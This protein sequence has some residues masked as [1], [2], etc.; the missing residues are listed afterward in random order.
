MAD[1]LHVASLLVYLHP[2]R[3]AAAMA[4]IEQLRGTELHG[5][6]P[7]GKVI[8]VIESQDEHRITEHLNGISVMPGVLSASLIYH[9][10][11]EADAED[12][13][14]R[15]DHPAGDGLNTAEDTAR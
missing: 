8:V 9:E 3:A 12:T 5:Y 10:V 7:D 6:S 1:E 14:P 2:D 11:D 13:P 4:E 15:P